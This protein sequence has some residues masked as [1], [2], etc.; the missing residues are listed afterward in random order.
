LVAPEKSGVGVKVQVAFSERPLPSSH[1]AS[2]RR[3][4]EGVGPGVE[5]GEQCRRTE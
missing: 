1:N 5:V 2:V 4:R 3:F